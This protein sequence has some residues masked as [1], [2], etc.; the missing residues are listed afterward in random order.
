MV[1]RNRCYFHRDDPCRNYARPAAK[2]V[3]SSS[4]VVCCG[5]FDMGLENCF[6][7]F[8]WSSVKRV[9]IAILFQLSLPSFNTIESGSKCCNSTSFVSVTLYTWSLNTC[10]CATDCTYTHTHTHARLSSH[11]HY[12]L[13]HMNTQGNASGKG[14]RKPPLPV[15]YRFIGFFFFILFRK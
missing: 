1:T 6:A 14:R 4:S 13:S 12:H 10:F 9:T 11:T 15:N 2:L 3:F 5:L 8:L 7:S